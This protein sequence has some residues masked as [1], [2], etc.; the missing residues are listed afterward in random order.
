[1][2]KHSLIL[3]LLVTNSFGILS[4]LLKPNTPSEFVVFSSSHKKTYPSYSESRYREAV[5]NKNLQNIKALKNGIDSTYS[6]GVTY[7]SDL[8]PEEFNLKILNP[9]ISTTPEAAKAF[10]ELT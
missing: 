6:Q 4:P 2:I 10:L 5:F 9:K 1:M 8:T 7:Y 3:L